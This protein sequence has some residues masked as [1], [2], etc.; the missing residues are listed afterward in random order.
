MLKQK[1]KKQQIKEKLPFLYRYNC[2]MLKSYHFELIIKN[3][4][5]LYYY[6]MSRSVS[7]YTLCNMVSRTQNRET[8]W[9][10]ITAIVKAT[11]SRVH[12]QQSG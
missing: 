3:W 5:L 1:T 7:F 6:M 12:L 2:F 8:C 4:H 11:Y 10:E 9:K